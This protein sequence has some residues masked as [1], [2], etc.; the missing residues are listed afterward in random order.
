MIKETYLK[1]CDLERK[2]RKNEEAV[3][4]ELLTTK[5]KVPYDKLCEDLRESRKQLRLQY[6]EAIRILADFAAESVY[7]DLEDDEERAKLFSRFDDLRRGADEIT[8][9]LLNSF[10][11]TI[12]RYAYEGREKNG[13]I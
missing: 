5:Y 4:M 6:I 7:Y 2:K 13:H 9:N 10:I 11:L 12:N 8:V 3:S 1:V